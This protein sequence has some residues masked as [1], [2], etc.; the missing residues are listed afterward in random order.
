[1]KIDL[2]PLILIAATLLTGV[3]VYLLVQYILDLAKV[4]AQQE[5]LRNFQRSHT[6]DA[7]QAHMGTQAY[8][9]RQAFAALGIDVQGNEKQ[10]MYAAMAVIGGLVFVAMH[11]IG[12]G[13]LLSL[14]AGAGG[15]YLA[16]QS[17]IASRWE[18]TRL[19]LEME[20][21]TF[22]RNLSGIIQTDPNVISAAQEAVQALDPQGPLAA[23]LGY[24]IQSLSTGGARRLDE[25]Q[26]EAYEISSSLGLVV[27][28]FR[29]LW[30]SGGEGYAKAFKLAADNLSEML[31]VR[32]QAASKGTGALSL[33][34]LI[35]GAAILSLGYILASPMGKDIYLDNPLLKL[36]LFGVVGW[37]IY[38]WMFIKD[39]VREATE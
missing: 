19:A 8:K 1:M 24:F 28:E 16:V 5:T 17:I 18:K 23:W 35:I 25:L 29:R 34:R 32:A 27:F 10:T 11:M 15:G 6:P 36:A 26:A 4:R 7:G 33:A 12:L 13:M 39:M 30:E 31:T 20:I 14:L 37:G 21:P 22:L 2:Y 38:G 9:I 3:T